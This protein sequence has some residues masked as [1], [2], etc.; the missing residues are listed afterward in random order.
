MHA[1]IRA[2]LLKSGMDNEQIGCHFNRMNWGVFRLTARYPHLTSDWPVELSPGRART[3]GQSTNWPPHSL[4]RHGRRSRLEEIERADPF[5][6]TMLVNQYVVKHAR[7]YVFSH[8]ESHDWARTD[9][10][11]AQ[12]DAQ[13]KYTYSLLAAAGACIAFAITQTQT[14]KLTHDSPWDSRHCLGNELLQ[15]LRPHLESRKFDAEKLPDV[16]FPGEFTSKVPQSTKLH[17]ISIQ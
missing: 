17:R 1:R 15:R 4:C 14:A 16:A 11:K 2:N 3:N 5:K 12:R 10:Y 13:E 8:D 7:R 9:L 6:L